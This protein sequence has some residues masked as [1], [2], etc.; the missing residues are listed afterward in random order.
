VLPHADAGVGRPEVDPDG[1]TLA[2]HHLLRFARRDLLASG[3][4][5]SIG[6]ALSWL[7]L[8]RSVCVLSDF[9][10]G[11]CELWRRARRRQG[12]YGGGGRVWNVL[13]RAIR[14]V[15][16]S[17]VLSGMFSNLAVGSRVFW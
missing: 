13:V 2:L 15:R 4:R 10:F 1:R 12:F 9:E 16:S 7:C 5:N 11:S 6:T 8:V 14:A 3:G 17:G